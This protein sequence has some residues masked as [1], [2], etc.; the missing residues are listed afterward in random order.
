MVS[1]RPAE[2]G[3]EISRWLMH[4]ADMKAEAKQVTEAALKLP[5]RDRLQV[6][7]A[8]WKSMG[9][10]E[11]QLADLAAVARGHELDTGKVIPKSQ[12]EVFQ[13]ARAVLG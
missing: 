2:T 13:K 12:S 8:I 4:L 5:E 10:S 11:E 7:S 9:G 3:V 1:T 6:A